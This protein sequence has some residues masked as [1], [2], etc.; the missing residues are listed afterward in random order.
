MKKLIYSLLSVWFISAVGCQKG[1]YP[2]ITLDEA[3]KIDS[4]VHP[5]IKNVAFIYNGNVYYAADFTRPIT[6]VTTDGS[7]AK[8][9]KVSHDHSK[10]AYLNSINQITIVDNKGSLIATLSQYTQ[11]KSF[12][13]SADDKT[14]YILNDNGI[15]YYGPAMKLPSISYQ[16]FE[17][18]SDLEVVSASVSMTGDIAYVVKGFDFYVGEKYELIIKPANNGK[19]IEYSNQ[20]ETEYM[21]DYVSFSTNNQDL[22][23]GYNSPYSGSGAQQRLQFFTGLNSYPDGGYGG[24]ASATPIYNST[25]NYL[26]AGKLNADN[27]I[28]PAALYLG[29]TPVYTSANV[30][31]TIVLDKYTG[32]LYIDW[33]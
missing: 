31:K 32:V 33:K 7:A 1:P 22:V 13:W 27:A 8:F 28:S 4:L 11:V 30:A 5:P 14:L 6:Q 26:V 10:F 20:D 12:D 25:L 2:Y 16:S 15:A 23:L 19:V 24:G 29:E 9:V 17:S 18:L 3:K 21:M